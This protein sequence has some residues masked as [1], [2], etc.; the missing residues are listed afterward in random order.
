[1][2]LC[3]AA[4]SI[5]APEVWELLGCS[6]PH[7]REKDTDIVDRIISKVLRD[8]FFSLQQPLESPDDWYIGILKNVKAVNT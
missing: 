4:N 1:V 7:P 3:E 8:L 5:G 2:T 6:A